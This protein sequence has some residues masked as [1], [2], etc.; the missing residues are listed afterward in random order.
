MTEPIDA[1]WLAGDA[2]DALRAADLQLF[3]DAAATDLTA[4]VP[5]CPEWDVTGL[6]DHLARVYQGRGHVIAHG[7]FLDQ[8][9]FLTRAPD[10]DPVEWVRRWSDELDR[11][12]LDRPDDAPTLTFVPEA[13][14]VHFWRR[15]MALETLVHRTDAELAVGAVSVMDDVLSADGIDELLWFFSHPDNDE[16]EQTDGIATTST[17]ELTDGARSWFV[18]LADGAS[19]WS[20]AGGSPDVTV[21]GAAP[22]LLLAASGRDLDGIGADRFGVAPLVVEGDRAAYRRLLDRLGAF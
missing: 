7:T 14:T 1:S 4:Q 3:C 15:R 9:D 16:A 17:V 20:R 8:D 19:S 22:A 18:S 2:Y 12:L 6:C 21:R 11:A 10:D 13:T 5:T